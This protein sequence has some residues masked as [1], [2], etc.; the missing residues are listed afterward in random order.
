MIPRPRRGAARK[1]DGLSRHEV[2]PG[3]ATAD[4]TRR[5]Y[6]S[7]PDPASTPTVRK[8]PTGIACTH[9]RQKKKAKALPIEDLE[10]IVAQLASAGTLKAGRDDALLQIGFI[11][12]MR[13]SEL[14]AIEV[15]HV[16]WAPGR[17]E[18]MLRLIA[19][20]LCAA[21]TPPKRS[22]SRPWQAS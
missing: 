10:R 11:G 19:K 2:L 6:R 12:G 3:A 20:R 4:N 7:D 18:I 22:P 8:T 17:I 16:G 15:E 5:A 14:V 13:R 21:I 9:G 1:P